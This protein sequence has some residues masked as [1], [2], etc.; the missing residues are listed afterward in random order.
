M[1]A[2]LD[3]RTGLRDVVDWLDADEGAVTKGGA[4]V[5]TDV[6]SRRHGSGRPGKTR[7]SPGRREICRSDH[8][9]ATARC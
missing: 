2:R 3:P 9:A 8:H 4:N 7:R 1:P 5:G 6:D